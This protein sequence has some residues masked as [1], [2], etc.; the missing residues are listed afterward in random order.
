MDQRNRCTGSEVISNTFQMVGEFI[1]PTC[2]AFPRV[3]AKSDMLLLWGFYPHNL[4]M[5]NLFHMV[6][7]YQNIFKKL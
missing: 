5:G 6:L 2:A 3:M 1:I 7:C 4:S